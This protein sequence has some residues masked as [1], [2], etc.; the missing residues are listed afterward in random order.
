MALRFWRYEEYFNPRSLHGERLS[1]SLLP[2]ASAA[3]QSTLPARGAT[4]CHCRRR[5]TQAISIH[6][7]CTGSDRDDAQ[8]IAWCTEFQST[9]PARGA[10]SGAGAGISSSKISIHAPRTGSD[11]QTAHVLLLL[12]DFNPRS[13]HG[14]RPNGLETFGH[15]SKFQSTLP[16]RGATLFRIDGM[17]SCV[18]ISI[19]APRTGSDGK[20][21]IGC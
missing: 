18:I 3:F 19:H 2:S 10:T 9:L 8:V 14:E 15:S 5:Y 6:A 12:P 21:Q 1:C 17:T 13:P 20:S 4:R 7:P 11:V 16:A